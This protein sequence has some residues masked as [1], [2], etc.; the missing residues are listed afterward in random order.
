MFYAYIKNSC[1][2]TGYTVKHC[3]NDAHL[4][5][6]EHVRSGSIITIT[7]KELSED[8]P[9]D[10]RMYVYGYETYIPDDGDWWDYE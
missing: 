1:I 7:Y 2:A 10:E 8:D 5:C 6:D 4:W 3:K 9:R